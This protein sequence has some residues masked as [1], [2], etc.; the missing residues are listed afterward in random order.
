MRPW[1]RQHRTG[2]ITGLYYICV[3]GELSST[4]SLRLREFIQDLSKPIEIED[5]F[6][7]HFFSMGNGMQIFLYNVPKLEYKDEDI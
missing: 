2:K 7:E 3:K 4:Y 5:G 6:S 1:I